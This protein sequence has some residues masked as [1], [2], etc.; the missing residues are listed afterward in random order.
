[1]T[2]YQFDGS[3]YPTRDQY[4]YAIATTYIEAEGL[5]DAEFI[6]ETLASCTD[7]E[8]AAECANM[9]ALDRP[10]RDDKP[11]PMERHGYTSEDLADA[12]GRY[13]ATR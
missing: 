9:W 11:S 7:A 8:L 4:L 5:N 13:R 12:F 6:T 2:N 10:G 3:L 1:M